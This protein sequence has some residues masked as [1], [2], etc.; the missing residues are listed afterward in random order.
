MA[1]FEAR[2]CDAA[3]ARNSCGRA[4][5]ARDEMEAEG[6]VPAVAAEELARLARAALRDFSKRARR[7]DSTVRE[8]Q[9]LRLR[10]AIARDVLRP[11]LGRLLRCA[12]DASFTRLR[13]AEWLEPVLER[14]EPL[15]GSVSEPGVTLAALPIEY[16]V[17]RHD[18][19]ARR[20]TRTALEILAPFGCPE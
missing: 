11:A 7:Y 4:V 20:E 19:V 17:G 2:V 6:A 9:L 15:M 1:S 8:R 16:T 10:R 18:D 3:A 14:I 12:F 5:P 13:P